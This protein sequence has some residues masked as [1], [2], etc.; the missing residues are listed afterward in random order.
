MIISKDLFIFGE[1]DYLKLLRDSR[2]RDMGRPVTR[3]DGPTGKTRPM[4]L[5][6]TSLSVSMGK[7]ALL[8]EVSGVVQP[9]EI[10]AV[11]GPSGSGKT[12][13]LNAISGRLPLESGTI[14]LNGELLN[15]KLRRKI[16]YVLQHDVFFPDLTLKQT[17]VYTALLRLPEAM[18]YNDKMQHVNHIIEILDLQRCQDTIIGDGLRRGLSGGEKKRANIACELLTNPAL[19]LLDEPTSGLDSSTAHSLMTT[20]KNY[21]RQENKTVVLTVHQPSSQIFYMFDRLLLLC[22]GQTA[23]FGDTKKVVDF[24]KHIGLPIE[25]HYNPA[26]FILEQVKGTAEN[27]ERII[28]SYRETRSDPDLAEQLLMT[29]GV[30]GTTSTSTIYENYLDGLHGSNLDPAQL[31]SPTQ[32]YAC[33]GNEWHLTSP[34]SPPRS[35]E[36]RLTI[37]KGVPCVYNKIA[38][39]EEDS[40]RSSWSD[41]QSHASHSTQASSGCHS[42]PAEFH[43]DESTKWPTSFWTQFKVLSR[44]NFTVTRPRMLSRLN[45]I[46]TLGLGLM[47][48]LLWF[49]VDRKEETLTNIQGWMFFSTTYWMLFALFGALSSFPSEQEVIKKERQSGAYRLSAYYMAKMVGE[50]PLIITLPAVYH[51]IS[52]PMLAVDFFNPGTFVIQLGFLLLNTVVAQSAGLFIGAACMDLEVSITISALYTLA[53]QLFGGFLSTSIPAWMEWMRY[54]SLVHY[55]FQNMQIVEF[56][57]NSPVRCAEKNSRFDACVNGAEEIPPHA[58]LAAS[59]GTGFPLWANTL[60]LLAFLFVFRILGYMVLRYFRRPR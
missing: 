45:W 43:W 58:I 1:Q 12:T 5:H 39:E 22:N 35:V 37:E 48:G 13:L 17:L 6:F 42:S 21:A 27:Q 18:S 11:M 59:G 23:Y 16:C 14:H 53:S 2:K 29:V 46:Q 26:D 60:L 56:N 30:G 38:K 4:D 47:S 31:P 3:P 44:R 33:Q 15:K 20:L 51:I 40:G 19:L 41:N 49:R 24:F 57:P 8:N 34:P 25:P 7:R 50:L 54:F 9:G 10:L 36:L 32:D 28:T 52:Y 55:A